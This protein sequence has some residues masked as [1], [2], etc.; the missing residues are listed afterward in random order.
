M[1]SLADF[2]KS[3]AEGT[4]VG[5]EWARQQ[6]NAK[7]RADFM[8]AGA[9]C[10]VCGHKLA[11]CPVGCT[12]HMCRTLLAPNDGETMPLPFPLRPLTTED[13]EELEAYFD[14]KP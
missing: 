14:E 7:L 2:N 9:V 13:K 5:H 4:T 8:A 10:G 1:G 11:T 3:Q 6:L 12:C